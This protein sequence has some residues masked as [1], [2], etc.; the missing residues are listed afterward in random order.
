MEIK[1]KKVSFKKDGETRTYNKLYV[2]I[3]DEVIELEPK[4]KSEEQKK[5]YKSLIV[6]QY[7]ED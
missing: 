3:D 5:Y 6:Q 4:G 7:K 2:V 1:Y